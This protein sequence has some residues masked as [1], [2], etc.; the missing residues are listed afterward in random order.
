[1]E[2]AKELRFWKYYSN[3]RGGAKW[4]C[5]LIRYL[6]D[7]QLVRILIDIKNKLRDKS[8]K[9]MVETLFKQDFSNISPLPPTIMEYGP[10]GESEEHNRL[11]EW[12]AKHPEALGLTNVKAEGIMEYE[13]R[14]GD[15]ADIVI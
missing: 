5:G 12:I 7:E 14:S 3:R 1:M 8:E 13:F 4:V 15:R 9:K 11:K 6:N 2:D 10:G